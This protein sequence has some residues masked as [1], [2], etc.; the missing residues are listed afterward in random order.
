LSGRWESGV[1]RRVTV[2]EAYT[3]QLFMVG[4]KGLEEKVDRETYLSH[5]VRKREI[6]WNQGRSESK[7]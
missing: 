5:R 2:R 1:V 3:K 7:T 6:P 4:K